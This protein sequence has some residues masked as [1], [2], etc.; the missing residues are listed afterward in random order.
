MFCHTIHTGI[1]CTQV[2]WTPPPTNLSPVA[3]LLRCRGAPVKGGAPRLPLPRDN[4]GMALVHAV[5][6]LLTRVGVFPRLR[7]GQNLTTQ[8]ILAL[9]GHD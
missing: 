3:A 2:R 1:S 4:E 6:V 9:R 8:H 7:L 5:V